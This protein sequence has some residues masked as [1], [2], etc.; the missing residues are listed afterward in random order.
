MISIGSW[1]FVLVRG[2]SVLRKKE[3][4]KTKIFI[5]SSPSFS[6]QSCLSFWQ[7]W[8]KLPCQILKLTEYHHQQHCVLLVLGHS[9]MLSERV[10]FGEDRLS[11]VL[12]LGTPVL[13][14]KTVHFYCGFRKSQ[15]S[16]H[17]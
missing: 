11:P 14:T 16:Q 17:C 9:E 5:S 15:L 12:L 3:K 10:C 7:Q 1:V 8:P 6:T 2:M 13:G 4:K